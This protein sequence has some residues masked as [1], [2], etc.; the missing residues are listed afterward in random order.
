M[1][2]CHKGVGSNV[3]IAAQMYAAN[4][5]LWRTELELRGAN[6]NYVKTTDVLEQL[7]TQ[8]KLNFQ[9]PSSF[10]V[11]MAPDNL[12]TRFLSMQ[13]RVVEREDRFKRCSWKHHQN[14]LHF[15]SC[16]KGSGLDTWEKMR[17]LVV[18][19]GEA[20]WLEK[21]VSYVP[22]DSAVTQ[23]HRGSQMTAGHRLSV[24][25]RRCGLNT[26]LESGLQNLLPKGSQM[27]LVQCWQS[28]TGSSVSS[29]GHF[30]LEHLSYLQ[31]ATG[32]FS[33]YFT[34]KLI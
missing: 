21:W 19:L 15:R 22:A 8:L 1:G 24:W 12:R 10:V 16:S 13:S 33:A 4:V 14:G 17:S 26:N 9:E 18:E 28:L 7:A 32:C 3:E 6:V 34:S 11:S 31:I 23:W 2:T 27:V 5:R 29:T 25:Q 30:C 20:D